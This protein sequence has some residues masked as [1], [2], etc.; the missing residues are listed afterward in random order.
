[1]CVRSSTVSIFDCRVDSPVKTALPIGFLG[2]LSY[3]PNLL[4]HIGGQPGLLSFL[5]AIDQVNRDPNLLPHHILVPYWNDS[6]SEDG[7]I[8]AAG[9]ELVQ[10]HAIRGLVGEYTSEASEIANLVMRL[11][12]IPQVSF[13]AI[14]DK[15]DNK[16]LYPTF[17]RII[18]NVD[19]QARA[20]CRLIKTLGWNQMGMI[21]SSTEVDQSFA[22]SFRQEAA[23]IGVKILSTQ[24]IP[25]GRYDS[26]EFT[27]FMRL[28][29]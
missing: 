17:F 16:A 25:T 18:S 26:V 5:V 2:P 28:D 3:P 8:M 13:S 12:S 9:L 19:Y 24:I 4:A 11:Y 29:A 20:L 27:N 15:F 21:G 1:M 6:R 7:Q 22:L 10:Q 23:I 14:S